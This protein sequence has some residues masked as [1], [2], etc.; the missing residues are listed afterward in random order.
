MRFRVAASAARTALAS[1]TA[2]ALVL[3][4]LTAPELGRALRLRSGLLPVSTITVQP[5]TAPTD[6]GPT[7]GFEEPYFPFLEGEDASA[8]I[9]VG[10]TSHGFVVNAARV[11]QDVRLGILPTQQA[12]GLDYG[13]E[14]LVGMLEHVATRLY[15][16]TKT[17]LWIGN[18]GKR[19]GGDIGFSVSH[20]S[21]RDADIAFCYTDWKGRPV[22]PTDLVPLN[23]QGQA[24]K[25]GLRLDVPRTWIVVKALLRYPWARVQYLFIAGGLKTQLLA[26]ARDQ[27]ESPALIERAAATLRSPVGSAPHND[28]LHLR[29][30]CSERD[31]L[32]GCVHTGAVHPWTKL[33]ETA[34]RART[35]S[36]AA[37][38]GHADAEQRKRA[39]ERLVLLSGSVHRR[40][41]TALLDDRASTVR[42]AAARAIAA[43]GGRDDVKTL[44]A[45]F[46]QERDALVRIAMVQAVGT[47]GGP[48]AG[49]FLSTAV[50]HPEPEPDR[51]LRAFG[52]VPTM[53]GPARLSLLRL[54][55]DTAVALSHRL[56]TLGLLDD[57]S[58]PELGRLGGLGALLS[59]T[60]LGSAPT[61]QTRPDPRRPD[62]RRLV[63]LAAIEAA[64]KSRRL[65]PVP[66][67]I[68]LLED[69]DATVRASVGRALRMIT[70]LS[71]RVRWA[72]ASL[73]QRTKGL[74]RWRAAWQRS[75][76]A[77]R[78]AWLITGFKAAG[79]KVPRLS[80]KRTWELLRA[81]AGADHL[82]VNAQAVL[83]RLLNHRPPG[84]TQSKNEACQ[85]WLRWIRTRRKQYQ[86]DK[87][88]AK[89][90]QACFRPAP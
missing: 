82:S 59:E 60:L 42:E 52:A 12:R 24:P 38:L 27:G 31:V 86:L 78:D 43:L 41:I 58:S 32:G 89:T 66:A 50:G 33:Y 46:G 54:L 3:A 55:P 70:N 18:I 61:D 16:A 48:T 25:H 44:S 85:Y 75:R 30:H 40:P 88:P 36:V 37:T 45:R 56:R 39:L 14:E 77:P 15:S 53:V 81:V 74:E 73:E 76:G 67:L 2:L 49:R 20:N 21:G 4:L 23:G 35:N 5:G 69:R 51:L 79:Y 57:G 47:L 6:A 68:G 83:V 7:A 1:A 34:K 8:S 29:I 84:A 26:H 19:G 87:P 17:R 90:T 65:E 10:D 63:Q 72:S 64:S 11:S 80:Q 9:S 22:D 71:Y 62:Q 13:T 28:H